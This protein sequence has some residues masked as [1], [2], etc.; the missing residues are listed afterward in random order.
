[1]RTTERARFS[2]GFTLIELLVVIAIIAV[3]IGLLLPAVQKVREAAARS[4]CSNN[5]KQQGL[6]MHSL[7]D[8]IGR[9]P[10]AIGWFPS[11]GPAIG[12]GWGTFYF[13]LL[14]DIEQA[15][16]YQSGSMTG[17]N[18]I[19]QDPGGAYYSGEAGAGTPNYVSTRVIKIYIC[20]VDPSVPGGGVYTD[21][22]SNLQWGAGSYAGN[23]QLFGDTVV[24][25]SL[26]GTFI[27]SYQGRGNRFPTSVPDG[28]TNTI[29][30]AEKYARCESDAFGIRRGT[31]WGWWETSGYVYHPLFAWEENWGTGIGPAS[32]FQIQPTPFIGNCDPGRPATAHSNGMLVCLC[33]GSVR[34]LN[35]AMDSG[36]WWSAVTPAGEEVLGNDW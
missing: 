26:V 23:F 24:S 10:P 6:A 3:L 30:F 9:L 8:R 14:P 32:K 12:S 15:P 16:I 33:D 36:T 27:S 18:S 28:L 31:L 1:M 5:L 2:R 22:V 19:G 21:T 35:A 13:H 25:G 7:N 20:P 29:L 11:T 34:M 17:A 4:Q